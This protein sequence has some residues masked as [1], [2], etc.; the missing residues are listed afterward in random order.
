MNL[1][2][3]FASVAIMLALLG[4]RAETQ[5]PSAPSAVSGKSPISGLDLIPLKVSTGEKSYDFTVE[6]ARTDA[7]QARGM[8]YRERLAP[9]AGML[10]PFPQPR[11]ASFWMQNTPEPLDLIFVRADGTIARI[12]VNAVPYSTDQV[13]VS[14][15]VAA[16][17]EI[18]GGRS[19]ELGIEE[20]DRVGWPGGPSL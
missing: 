18:A 8:M 2:R 3:T 1:R 14:E 6:V 16:V 17:L 9:F 7:E 11:P 12:A 15:P 19:I 4:C 20:G 10:F 13:A 5:S